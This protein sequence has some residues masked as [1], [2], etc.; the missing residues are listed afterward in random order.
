MNRLLNRVGFIEIV[1]ELN[2]VYKTNVQ[3]Q[4]VPKVIC[5]CSIYMISVKSY[6]KIHYFWAEVKRKT[7]TRTLNK[8][9]LQFFLLHKTVV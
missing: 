8:F 6:I 2:P 3:I 4:D 9:S 1:N 7:K 5:V